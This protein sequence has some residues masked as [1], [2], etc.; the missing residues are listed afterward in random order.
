MTA[1]RVRYDEFVARIR[2]HRP[3]ELLTEIA[4]TTVQLEEQGDGRWPAN[5]RLIFPWALAAAARESIV[6]GNEH[7]QPGVSRG[8][9]EQIC[10]LYNNLEDPILDSDDEDSFYSF[11]VRLTYEQFSYQISIFEEFARPHLLFDDALRTTDTALID[12]GF[13]ERLLGCTPVELAGAI[14]V[15]G[16]G[17]Q[18]NGGF[19]DPTWLEQPNFVPVLEE[20]PAGV[21]TTALDSHLSATVDTFRSIAAQ[22][23]SPDLRLRRADYNP[24]HQ[25]PYV[26]LGDGRF[27]APIPRLV[28][29]RMSPE[30]LY[31]LALEKLPEEEKHAFTDDVGLL[32]QS[33]VGT[34]LSSIPGATVLPEIRYGNDELSVDWFVIWPELVLLVEAKSTR[35]TL[36]SRLGLSNLRNDVERTLGKAFDQLA[37]TAGLIDSGQEAF[38]NIPRDRPMIGFATTMEPYWLGNAPVIRRFLP[39]LN[40]PTFVLSM[41]ELEHLVAI[42]QRTALP[43]ILLELS[44]DKE[45]RTWNVGNAVQDVEPGARN[46]LLDEAWKRLPF[47]EGQNH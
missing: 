33:Y 14:F 10:N 44:G 19:F 31:Y 38:A 15:L 32:F 24:L 7:R 20:V 17:A 41:R 46:P 40:I 21:I 34:Q 37:T 18:R 47:G 36:S 27:I 9:I 39:E 30:G 25:A 4:R 5:E 29:A 43:P 12:Q 3:S 11:F 35:L 8:D 42:A 45:R 16:V 26:R 22:F 23:R 2:R 1:R 6:A 13:W 28:F